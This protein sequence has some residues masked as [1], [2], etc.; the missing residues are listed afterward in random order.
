MLSRSHLKCDESQGVFQYLALPK[1]TLRGSVPTSNLPFSAIFES[2]KMFDCFLGHFITDGELKKEIIF[3]NIQK[4]KCSL[5]FGGPKIESGPQSFYYDY[6][7]CLITRKTLVT[8]ACCAEYYLVSETS[9]ACEWRKPF[10]RYRAALWVFCGH[11]RL[12][13]AIPLL[14]FWSTSLCL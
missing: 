3:V 6:K 12:S 10:V 9:L 4:W 14:C 7:N 2:N 8:L 11:A 5:A 1:S 13:H